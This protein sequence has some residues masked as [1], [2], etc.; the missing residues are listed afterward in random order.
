[1]SHQAHNA[2]SLTTIQ[3][4]AAVSAANTA[5]A[6]SLGIDISD[7]EG[8][9]TV[10]QNIGVVSGGSITGKLVTSDAS[11]LSGSVDVP[12]G[13]FTAV[14]TSTDP[15]AES[16]HVEVSSLKKYIGY[17]GTIVTG[18]VLVGVTAVGSKKIV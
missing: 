17:V 1:M 5:A 18:G 15:A 4:L 13:G 8:V 7:Y 6:T 11:D 9:L 14:T 10:T 12:G 16:L 2:K 3:I